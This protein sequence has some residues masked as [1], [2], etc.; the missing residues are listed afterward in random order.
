MSDHAAQGL[1]LDGLSITDCKMEV[2]YLRTGS[3][4][5]EGTSMLPDQVTQASVAP[6][7]V[8]L[9]PFPQFTPMASCV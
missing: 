9:P 5:P 7:S 1:R 8:A 3:R 6:S 2:I 4:G